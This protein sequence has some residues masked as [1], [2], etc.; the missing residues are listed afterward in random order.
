MLDSMAKMIPDY[1]FRMITICIVFGTWLI[2]VL[3][4]N[5]ELVLGL[6]GST[7]GTI[8][9]I[10]LPTIMFIK[11]VSKNTNEKLLAQV[12]SSIVLNYFML[13]SFQWQIFDFI[14]FYNLLIQVVFGIGV[15]VMVASTYATLQ[16]ADKAAIS[17]LE[18]IEQNL[19]ASR[20]I[21]AGNYRYIFC[22]NVL[23]QILALPIS[24]FRSYFRA[25]SHEQFIMQW[26]RTLL[27][28][29]ILGRAHLGII[30]GVVFPTF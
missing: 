23:F 18:K 9:C 13:I 15:F 12:C 7:V 16:N 1:Q 17:N 28:M 11:I 25:H 5:I 30:S 4:P 19:L 27:N 20:Q 26:T 2:G 10:I 6:N 22:S 21:K 14:A 8:I 24:L 3:I 29:P